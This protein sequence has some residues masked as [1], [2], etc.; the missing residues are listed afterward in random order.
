MRFPIGNPATQ[1]T[2]LSLMRPLVESCLSINRNE[3]RNQFR[4]LR[5]A[6]EANGINQ[7]I[8]QRFPRVHLISLGDLRLR[9]FGK[10]AMKIAERVLL[11]RDP[12][13]LIEG[14]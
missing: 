12:V 8:A 10:L 4:R 7:L 1:A 14:R 11:N 5:S 9:C 13:I 2:A 3:R 6:P